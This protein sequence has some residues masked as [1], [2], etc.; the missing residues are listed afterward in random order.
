MIVFTIIGILAVLLWIPK[1]VAVLIIPLLNK[2][3]GLKEH[4]DKAYI[5]LQCNRCFSR[6]VDKDWYIIPTI[7]VNKGGNYFEVNISWLKWSYYIN[8]SYSNE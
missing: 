7:S 3:R 5:W 6:T 8:Y 1:M 4:D 2:S